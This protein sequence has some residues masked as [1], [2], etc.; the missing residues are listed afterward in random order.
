MHADVR[1]AVGRGSDWGVYRQTVAV[2]S[3]TG[4]P[5]ATDACGRLTPDESARLISAAKKGT[6]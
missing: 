4:G 5:P 3:P 1:L 2:D 6:D